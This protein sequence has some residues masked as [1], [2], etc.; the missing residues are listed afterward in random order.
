MEW[1]GGLWLRGMVGKDLW[2]DSWY[3]NGGEGREVFGGVGR[4]WIDL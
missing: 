3:I 2:E 1:L 4:S